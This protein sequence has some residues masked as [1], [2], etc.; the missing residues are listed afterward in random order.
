MAHSDDDRFKQLLASLETTLETPV[1]PGELTLWAEQVVQAARAFRAPLGERI[2]R[3]HTAR[4]TEIC[5]EDPALIRRTEQLRDEDR[6]ILQAYDQ[7]TVQSDELIRRAR[8][9]EPD[10]AACAN[11]TDRLTRTGLDLV[12]RIRKQELAIVTWLEEASVRDRGVKD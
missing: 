11:L 4:F 12:I 1:V 5:I 8:E 3:E 9:A 7:F 6:E 10:E 2:E